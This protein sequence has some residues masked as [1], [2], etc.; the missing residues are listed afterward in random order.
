MLLEKINSPQDLKALSIPQLPTLAQE[1]RHEIIKVVSEKGGHLASNLGTVELILAL[2]YVFNA[3]KDSLLFDVGHQAYAHKLLTGRKDRF[4]TLRQLDGI[5]GYPTRGESPYDLFTTGHA[6][7]ALS[8]ALGIATARDL[9]KASEKVIAVIGDGSLTGG[10]CFEALNNTGHS[11]KD[12]IVI[13][14]SNEM[15]ISPN[16]GSLSKYLNKI[17]SQPVYN[18]VRDAVHRFV[19]L[20]MPRVGPRMM[21]ISERFEEFVKGLIVPGIFFEELG[22]RYF[23]PLDGHDIGS[24]IETF[25]NISLLKEPIVVHVITQKGKGYSPA[26]ENP[27]S[28]HGPAPFEL[29]TGIPKKVRDPNRVSYTEVFSQ[30]IVELARQDKRIVAVTAAMCEGTGLEKFREKIPERFFDVGIAE[31]H[32]V[33]F[34]AG[35]ASRGFKPVVAIYSTFLQRAYDQIVE[36]VSM[37][38]LP[39]IFVL[40]RAGIVGADGMSHQG[41]FDISYLRGIPDMTVMAP[42]DT[43]ELRDML[44]FAVHLG[45]AVAIRYPKEEIA[46]ESG[47]PTSEIILGFPQVVRKGDDVLLLALGSM[48][49]PSMQAAQELEGEGISAEVVNARFAKPLDQASFLKEISRFK[50]VVT[51]EEGV[52]EGGFGS[53]VL[54]LINNAGGK[55]HC[56]VKNIHLPS[57]F[58]KHGDRKLLVK[59][60]GLDSDGIIKTV[61]EFVKHHRTGNLFSWLSTPVGNILKEKK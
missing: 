58:I 19:E 17:I 16:V 45:K 26:E 7:S 54:E 41:L 30:K 48:V 55:P 37:Q 14:N 20:R 36:D 27:V 24:L 59:Q 12:L 50:K 49:L 56:E 1:I 22:F 33:C 46:V 28:Y 25:K 11:Q 47:L 53:A 51:L 8:L 52:L 31:G 23:G 9:A 29:E 39:V 57:E 43:A 21:K 13:L 2:H 38:G 5:S 4:S 61:K 3:P 6:S 15:S 60:Y 35:M 44:E 18:R 34:A 40:D 10:L 32:A 42:K